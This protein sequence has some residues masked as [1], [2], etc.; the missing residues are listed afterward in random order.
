MFR[1]LAAPIATVLELGRGGDQVDEL[2]AAVV[3]I[4]GYA[5]ATRRVLWTPL[6]Q[7]SSSAALQGGQSTFD[8]Q[9][10]YPCFAFSRRTRTSIGCVRHVA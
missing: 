6:N 2:A 8:V 4:Q 9:D 3:E 7:K 5:G 1:D 10:Q